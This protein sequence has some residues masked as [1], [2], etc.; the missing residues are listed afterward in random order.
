MQES[1]ENDAIANISVWGLFGRFNQN[2]NFDNNEGIAIITAPNGYGKT[3][4]LRIIDSI[5][6]GRYGFLW[7]TTFQ[8]I[9]VTLS[10]ERKIELWKEESEGKHSRMPILIKSS[11][12]GFD[13][14]THEFDPRAVASNSETLERYL[15]ISHIG[16]SQWVDSLGNR[17]FSVDEIIERHIFKIEEIFFPPST[18]P[19]WL[20]ESMSSVDVHLVGTQRLLSIEEHPHPWL[21]P[22]HKPSSS[23][24]VVERDAEHLAVH[25]SHLLQAYANSSQNLDQTFPERILERKS[26]R[27][28]SKSEI[29]DEIE[30]LTER[31]EQIISVGILRKTLGQPIQ[32]LDDIQDESVRRILEI[33][34]EDTKQ[35][36]GIFDEMYEK[37]QLFKEIIDGRFSSKL[38]RI[39]PDKGIICFDK[40]SE[41]PI[42]LSDLSSGEQHELVLIYNLLFKVETGSTILIDEPEISLHVAWQKRFISD[43]EKIKNLNKMRV[44]LATHSPQIVNG[45][46]DSIQDLGKNQ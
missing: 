39:D 42:P 31:R 27:H 41:E 1:R 25:I 29:Q 46:W 40:N 10:S 13:D 35:K 17:F 45:Y 9:V 12:F 3:V 30:N 11:G 22:N 5:F 20:Q 6:N 44:I 34:I 8:R 37:I 14:Q 19:D 2:L 33:Y 38:I 15:S 18:Y 32:P 28:M 26:G 23:S 4:I 16:S 7:K 24:S 21:S 36:L 43:L